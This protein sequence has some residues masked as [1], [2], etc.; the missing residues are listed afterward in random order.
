[1]T[2]ISRRSLMAGGAATLALTACSDGPRFLTYDGPEV[3]AVMVHKGARVLQL[4]HQTEVLKAWPI[5]LGFSPVG[6]KTRQGD[7]KTP[8]GT[9]RINRRN[10][11]SAYH[12]SLGISYPDVNDVARARAL[13]VN[14]GGDIFIHGTPRRFRNVRDWTAGCIAI[15]N[16]E[17]E[18]C[19][20]MVKD[21]TPIFIYA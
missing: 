4:Y 15:D 11:R 2:V 19:Y 14:P 16:R 3:T 17:V 21:G 1:M 10:P 9:Y 7:G 12:L 13:G 20:A 6:H 5:D 18:E 8:E